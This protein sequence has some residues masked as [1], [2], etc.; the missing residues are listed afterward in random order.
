MA[1]LCCNDTIGIVVSMCQSGDLCSL[2]LVSK[3]FN[4]IANKRIERVSR[5]VSINFNEMLHYTCNKDKL[6]AL[7]RCTDSYRV[8]PTVMSC[9][10]MKVCSRRRRRPIRILPVWLQHVRR[11]QS[12]VCLYYMGEVIQA[13]LKRFGSFDKLAKYKAILAEKRRLRDFK[14][15]N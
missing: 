6:R 3:S 9:L 10:H 13:S 12:E 7:K 5:N 1:G 15:T 4:R 2:R 8:T 14:C 11:G